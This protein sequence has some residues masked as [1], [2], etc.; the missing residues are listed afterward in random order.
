MESFWGGLR[1]RVGLLGVL[2][3]LRVRVG[4]LGVLGRL[5]VGVGLLEIL[6]VLGRLRVGV[7]LLEILGVLGRLWLVAMDL[8][9]LR[10]RFVVFAIYIWFYK[11]RF[12][13]FFLEKYRSI[14]SLSKV[15]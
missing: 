11:N 4:L 14:N 13:V 15:V 3:R 1:V 10:D 9:R 8:G 2:G 6:G 12:F 7:G 5:R